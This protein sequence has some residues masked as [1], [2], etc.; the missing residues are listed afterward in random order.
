LTIS[1][2]VH[3]LESFAFDD[4]YNLTNLVVP[5]ISFSSYAFEETSNISYLVI[6]EGKDTI[7]RE[8][9]DF[10]RLK[11]V[12][13]PASVTNIDS[14]AFS[15]AN[16]TAVFYQGSSSPSSS[17]NFLSKMDSVELVC[18]P[19][20][21]K[22]EAFCGKPV[23]KDNDTCKKFQGMFSRCYNG[24]FLNGFVTKLQ[25]K[26]A[27]EWEARTDGCGEY[28]CEE[29]GNTSVILCYSSVDT[30]RLCID[31]MCLDNWET[32]LRGWAIE[33]D[34]EDVKLEDVDIDAIPEAVE[35]L[36]HYGVDS[37]EVKAGVE[38]DE[39]G[40]VTKIVLF[41]DKERYVNTIVQ[42][43]KTIKDQGESC[44]RYYGILCNLTNVTVVYNQQ[45]SSSGASSHTS[46][47][48]S[49]GASSSAPSRASSRVVTD[50]SAASSNGAST[51]LIF[52][53]FFVVLEQL[54]SSSLLV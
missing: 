19:L 21:Y 50:L 4:C 18:V 11:S 12:V 36:T 49:S 15:G 13:I 28:R 17:C 6:G 1:D 10:T 9:N 43:L 44:L 34:V 54:A 8:Y 38:N 22:A 30:S 37:S 41:L 24:A 42:S 33:I 51:L 53:S 32:D 35:R 39:E 3:T 20:E 25:T 29:S 52:L 26:A 16:L 27:A 40:N 47:K 23:S 45:S 46:S 14:S 5:G 2:S 48:A 31:R 7:G